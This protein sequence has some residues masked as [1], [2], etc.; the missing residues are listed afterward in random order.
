MGWLAGGVAQ[1]AVLASDVILVL[2]LGFEVADEIFLLVLVLNHAVESNKLVV[3]LGNF[4]SR[5]TVI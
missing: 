4:F 1:G 3:K 2:V 5:F